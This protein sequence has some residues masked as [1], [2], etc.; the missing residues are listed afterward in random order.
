ME[1]E[2]REAAYAEFV[3]RISKIPHLMHIIKELKGSQSMRTSICGSYMG[4]FQRRNVIGWLLYDSVFPEV[5]R[6]MPLAVR[7]GAPP[8]ADYETTVRSVRSV[9][10]PLGVA[11]EYGELELAKELLALGALPDSGLKNPHPDF[12]SPLELALKR[13]DREMVVLLLERGANPNTPREGTH[14]LVNALASPSLEMVQLL[15][16]YGADWRKC[17]LEKV[18]ALPPE[19]IECFLALAGRPAK[20]VA[21]LLGAARKKLASFEW[22]RKTSPPSPFIDQEIAAWQEKVA[23]L[24]DT[25]GQTAEARQY[26]TS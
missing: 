17:S 4:F 20:E 11:A 26:H 25:E 21:T 3:Q 16:D 6:L 9:R 5:R 22:I 23:R 13:G 12:V 19:R 2:A 24:G 18:V 15:V 8:N 1:S 7:A 10:T 14:P